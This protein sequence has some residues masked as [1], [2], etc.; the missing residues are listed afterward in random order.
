MKITDIALVEVAGEF[1]ADE[2]R[3]EERRVDPLDIYPEF[4][5]KSI[6]PSSGTPGESVRRR[7]LFLE[8][9]TDEDLTGIFGPVDGPHAGILR[10]EMRPFLLGRDPLAIET[11]WDMLLRRNRHSR[12]GYYMMAMSAL[13]CAL[14]DLKG[15]ALGAPVYRLLG[16]PTQDPVPAYASMLGHSLEP[17]ALVERAQEYKRLGY[18]AQ[19]WFF[20]YGPGDGGEGATRN[21]DM[22]RTLRKAVGDDVAL[23]FD[24]FNSWDVPYAVDVGR[25]IAPFR[26]AWLEEPVPVD[27][28][29][30]LRTIRERAGVPVATGEHVYT[31]WQAKQLLEAGAVD[32]IQADPDW[33]GGISELVKIATVC[34]TY[35]V[36]LCPHGHSLHAALH[37]AAA[38]PHP[39]LPQVE[40]LIMHQRN[41][42]RF[43]KGYIEPEQGMIR[44]PG[45]PGLGIEIDPE[46]AQER[47]EVE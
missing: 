10:R 12:G 35:D 6:K 42:Q 37:V 21:V 44:P 9:R 4:G 39:V 33:C 28:I 11:V 46:K 18:R 26:P 31:R 36:P 23:M 3:S 13:D 38:C 2:I 5:G 7:A 24:A 17:D 14:W 29:D 8:V 45:T 16:G 34:S 1:P 43:M 22:A 47:R 27:R 20:R 41:K 40:F 19:K 15:K 30:A 25:R 32:V